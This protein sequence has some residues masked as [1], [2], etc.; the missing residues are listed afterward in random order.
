MALGQ[1]IANDPE[2]K[3]FTPWEMHLFSLTSHAID[4]ASRQLAE[5]PTNNNQGSV[6]RFDHAGDRRFDAAAARTR[7]G[8][9]LIMRLIDLRQ[10][11]HGLLIEFLKFGSD[12]TR[13]RTDHRPQDTIGNIV[14]AR[15]HQ[16]VVGVSPEFSFYSV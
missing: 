11:I 1:F 2:I 6:A 3:R 15:T 13:R 8:R 9:H 14:G 10:H 16:D 4:D 12:R 5:H 7:Q